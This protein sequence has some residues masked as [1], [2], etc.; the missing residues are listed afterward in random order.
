MTRG[1]NS[2]NDFKIKK[3]VSKDPHK[4]PKVKLAAS[5]MSA[6]GLLGHNLVK[7]NV[8]SFIIIT[9]ITLSC[10][11]TGPTATCTRGGSARKSSPAPCA[12]TTY[13]VSAR[14]SLT[15]PQK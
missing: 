15:A 9:R 10:N 13:I 2:P 5:L 7:T 14:S 1:L 4:S 8:F 11:T 3:E 6:A 12:M